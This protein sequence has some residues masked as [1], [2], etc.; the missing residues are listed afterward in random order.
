VLS[1]LGRLHR[2][3]HVTGER[4]EMS[5][6]ALEASPLV[7]HELGD[8]LGPAWAHRERLRLADALY[9]SLAQRLDTVVLTTDRRLAA[10]EACAE[11]PLN[12]GARA[13]TR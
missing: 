10:A 12:A 13:L 3:G 7:R 9:V 5:L 11:L 2:G 1:A 6:H 8:L 4:V